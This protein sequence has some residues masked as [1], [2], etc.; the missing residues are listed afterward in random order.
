MR[1]SGGCTQNLSSIPRKMWNFRMTALIGHPRPCRWLLVKQLINLTRNPWMYGGGRWLDRRRERRN[2]EE[3]EC[4]RSSAAPRWIQQAT[5]V[6]LPI[7]PHNHTLLVPYFP[8][9]RVSKLNTNMHNEWSDMCSDATG[10]SRSKSSSHSNRMTEPTETS[11]LSAKALGFPFFTFTF[12]RAP[13]TRSWGQDRTGKFEV[14]TRFQIQLKGLRKK[15]EISRINSIEIE[16]LPACALKRPYRRLRS[17][18]RKN[19]KYFF[20]PIFN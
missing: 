5:R 8:T 17:F 13:D 19:T 16:L 7:H 14:F 3:F 11:K 20:G 1:R 15:F 2:V 9:S 4:F 18:E 12:I 6:P 10:I